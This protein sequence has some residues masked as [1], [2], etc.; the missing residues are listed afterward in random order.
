MNGRN[1]MKQTGAFG[2]QTGW[3]AGLTALVLALG[4]VIMPES[5]FAEKKDVPVPDDITPVTWEVSEDHLMIDTDEA[6]ELYERIKAGDYPTVEELQDDPVVQELDR[7]SAYYSEVYG[8]TSGIQTEEREKLRGEILEKFLARGS[9]RTDHKKDDG[10]PVYVYDGPL[11]YDYQAV[12]VMG[13]PASGKSTRVADPTSEEL[14]AFNLDSDVIK[15]ELPEYKES[16]GAA[17]QSVHQESREILNK[18]VRSFTEGDMKGCN[19]IIQTIGN[20]YD[21][22]MSRYIEPFEKAGYNVK[23]KLVDA[24]LNESL[25]R[26]VMRGL[27]TG[28]IITSSAIIGYGDDPDQVY[29]K[30]SVMTNAKGE[31]YGYDVEAAADTKETSKEERTKEES[32]KKTTTTKNALTPQTIAKA[33]AESSRIPGAYAVQ[34]GDNLTK[35]AQLCNTTVDILT[36]VNGLTDP[37]LIYPGQVLCYF[38]SNQALLPYAAAGM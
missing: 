25:A 10:T 6:R 3:K 24:K 36:V 11:D 8:D 9:A 35:I 21:S 4:V 5:I 28:R 33:M 2:K 22:V 29:K 37:D 16:H 31:P 7:L 20:D 34:S 27:K 13:L 12:L 18:A 38:V 30:L 15:E 14:K 23:V 19:V 17:A 32:A 26:A 1:H